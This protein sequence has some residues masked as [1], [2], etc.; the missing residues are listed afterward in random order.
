[1]CLLIKQLKEKK[2]VQK[3][4]D[5]L[6]NLWG[7]IKHNNRIIEVLE[8]EREERIENPLEK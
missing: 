7:S 1:M 5:S 2:T 4:N 8:K 3:N 6:R